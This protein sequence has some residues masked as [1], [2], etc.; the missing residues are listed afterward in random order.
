MNFVSS[1]CLDTCGIPT[2]FN[3]RLY[4][5]F[6]IF[7]KLFASD[8]LSWK[9]VFEQPAGYASHSDAVL[10]GWD[11]KCKESYLSLRSVHSAFDFDKIVCPSSRVLSFSQYTP[12]VAAA[13]FI[14]PT[15][16]VSGDAEIGEDSSVWYG[17]TL[18]GSYSMNF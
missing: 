16:S 7:L 6:S 17:A 14:A 9:R 3:S 4:T 15:A 11:Q 5:L 13:R 18:R 12:K 8:R 2:F 10:I 1:V